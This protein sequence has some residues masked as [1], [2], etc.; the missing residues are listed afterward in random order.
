MT[1]G[2]RSMESRWNHR[3]IAT[4]PT[5]ASCPT[6]RMPSR[7][8]AWSDASRGAAVKANQAKS[9]FLAVMS[10]ELRTPLN[11]IGGYADIMKLGIY[12]ELNAQQNEALTRIAR[13]QQTLLALINDVLNFAKLEA[14]EV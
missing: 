4:P 6:G 1:S 7:R 2:R 14:G 12:G 13:S 8:S 9:D 3:R 10:H 11:A 5:S